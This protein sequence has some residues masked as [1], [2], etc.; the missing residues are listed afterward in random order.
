M[1]AE[2]VKNQGKSDF[3]RLDDIKSF[4]FWKLKVKQDFEI[5]QAKNQKNSQIVGKK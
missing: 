3:L 2:H 4:N 1:E 5:F